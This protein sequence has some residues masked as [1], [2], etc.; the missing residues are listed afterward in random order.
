MGS[1]GQ[2]HS[3]TRRMGQDLQTAMVDDK[4]SS[5]QRSVRVVLEAVFRMKIYFHCKIM[6]LGDLEE[7]HWGKRDKYLLRVAKML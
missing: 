6:Y 4:H 5:L 2:P 1:R 7:L 3:S